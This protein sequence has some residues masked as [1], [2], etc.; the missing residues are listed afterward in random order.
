MIGYV[1]AQLALIYNDEMNNVGAI[2]LKAFVI[3]TIIGV[4]LATLYIF[5]AL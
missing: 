4:I 3:G 1:I 5:M 2:Q